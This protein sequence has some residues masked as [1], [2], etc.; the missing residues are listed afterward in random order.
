EML[1]RMLNRRLK[2]DHES[3]M[4]FK[5][6]RLKFVRIGKDYHE[7]GLPILETM[8]TEAIK[9]SESYQL[10]IKY[11]TGQI[12]P[13]KSRGKGSQGKKTKKTSSKR[14]VKKKVTLSVDDNIIFDDPDAALELAKRI[15]K[16]EAKEAEEARQTKLKGAPSLTPEEQKAADIIQA[17]KERDEQD[18]EYSDDENDD[19]EKDGKDSDVDDEGDDH[20]SDTQDADDE[21]VETKSDE[22]DIYKY[23]IR[24]YKDEDDE[25]INA[26]VDDSD[27]GVEEI[28][29]AAMTDAKT[30]SE[31]KDDPKKN[32]LPPSSSS[33]SVFLGFGDQFL[34]LSS[35]SSLVSTVKDTTDM[36]IN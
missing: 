18:S 20:I 5:L 11:S 27:K 6:L 25:M 33:L 34:K 30:T 28:I 29:D 15:S 3:E 32:K 8:L 19:V 1:S 9:Q 14:R 12:R 2:V 21:D 24:V 22:D 17:L 35:D 4:A 23:K 31:V 10:F 36:D 7:Y 16:T 13:K 26:E